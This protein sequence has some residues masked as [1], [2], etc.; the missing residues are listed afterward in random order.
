MRV[1]G[2]IAAQG[3]VGK[4]GMMLEFVCKVAGGDNAMH[5]ERMFGHEINQYGK[6]VF[7]GAEDSMAS[8]HRRID[9]LP[10][11]T[12]RARAEDKLFIVPLPDAGG[13]LGLCWIRAKA[14]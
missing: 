13:P 3:G 12:I 1:P 10:D 2:L 4:S 5:T 9:G 7:I 14:M 6:A 8:L 11:Q